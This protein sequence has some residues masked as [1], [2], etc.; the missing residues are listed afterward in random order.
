VHKLIVFGLLTL[1]GGCMTAAEHEAQNAS[2]CESIGLKI[3][4]L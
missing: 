4:G 2:Y 3:R 1:L